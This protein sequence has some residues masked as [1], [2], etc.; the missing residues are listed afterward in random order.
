[1]PK[2]F[3]SR[4]NTNNRDGSIRRRNKL[5]SGENEESRFKKGDM[6]TGQTE[7]KS[8]TPCISSV[9]LNQHPFILFCFLSLH[10]PYTVIP[11]ISGLI[12]PKLNFI[13]SWLNPDLLWTNPTAKWQ[14]FS[15]ILTHLH[16]SPHQL[17]SSD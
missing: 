9:L 17:S 14:I 10:H 15:V 4:S 3:S 6:V 8:L 13:V 2:K 5:K 1:M 16:Y 11:L 12:G 7:T